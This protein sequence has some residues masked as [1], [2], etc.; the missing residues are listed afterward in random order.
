FHGRQS[1]LSAIVKLC[2]EASPRIAILGGGGMGKTSLARAALHHPDIAAKY[3]RRVFVECDSAT[4]R[5]ELAALIGSHIGLHPGK[6]LTKP[7]VK[8]FTTE[9]PC[10][11]ILDNLE[12]PWEPP[13]SRSGV[14]EFLSLLT[15][16]MHLALIITMR[17]A[18]R[19]AKVRWTHPFLPP[20]SPLTN[21]AARQTFLDITDEPPNTATMNR[22]LRLTD[23]MPLAVDLIAHLVDYEGSSNVLTRW[24]TERTALLSEGHDRRSSV[25][26]SIEISLSSPRITSLPGA[27]DLLSLLS[28]LPDGLS[29]AE[30]TQS[31]LPI[32]DLLTCK[33]TLLRTSLAYMDNKMRLKSLSPIR[34]YMDRTYPPSQSLIEPLQKHFHLLLQLYHRFVGSQS[35]IRHISVNL[36]NIQG[37]LTRSLNA[38]NQNIADAI[39]CTIAF[40]GFT[41]H[42]GQ[43]RNALMDN[44]PPLFPKPCDH[45]LEAAYIAEV[46][47]G[48]L[49][50]PVVNPEELVE[51]AAFHF[52]EYK[53]PASEGNLDPSRSY[54]I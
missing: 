37:I 33:T 22:L 38:N 21:E 51:Q 32:P 43:G 35:Q 24:E 10:L 47:R 23:N 15:D 2:S 1:E 12:T 26:A 49:D 52:S 54:P 17:G 29:D 4:T 14:E 27:K 13:H 18:E 44:L 8:Y 7:V 42:F 46:F 40:S 30:L 36:G 19:P 3:Q 9:G 28:A 5:L 39:E 6:D 31:M 48:T 25:D 45:K 20:L 50:S 41:R 53:N 16:V 34:Q 11:L